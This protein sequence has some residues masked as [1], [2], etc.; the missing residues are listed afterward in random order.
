MSKD[1]DN[2]SLPPGVTFHS[3]QSGPLG[4]L[5]REKNWGETSLGAA[6]TWPEPLKRYVSMIL[7]LPIPAIV[8]WG[9]NQIQIYNDSYSVTMGPRHPKFLGATYKECWP[10]TYPTIY[11]WMLQVLEKGE[12]IKVDRTLIPLT[13]YGFLE[14]CFFT[15]S[16]TPLQDDQKKIGGILQLVTDMTQTVLS[17]RR[18]ATLNK[19]VPDQRS[20]AEGINAIIK[21]LASNPQDI[22][23]A[24]LF[25]P[26]PSGRLEVVG[27]VGVSST[28]KNSSLLELAEEVFK[29]NR[30]R[31]VLDLQKWLPHHPETHW[32]ELTEKAHLIPLR[33]SEMDSPLGVVL[34]GISPRLAFDESYQDF[35]NSLAR[36]MS[37]NLLAIQQR[38]TQIALQRAKRNAELEREKL[39][40]LFFQAPAA[41]A[42]LNLPDLTFDFVNKPYQELVGKSREHLLGVPIKIVFPDLS[43][44]TQKIL[45]E[46]IASGK[47]YESKEFLMRVDWTGKSLKSERY[48]NFVYTPFV[49]SSETVGGVMV[50]AFDVTDQVVERRKAKASE[51]LLR[52]VTDKLPALIS[53]MDTSGRYQF[54]NL[55]YSKWFGKS[56]SEI[57]GKTRRD[58]LDNEKTYSIVEPHESRA[59]SGQPSSLELTLTKST[60]EYVNL[61]TEYLPDRSPETGEVIGII[62]VGHDVTLRKRALQE[63]EQAQ[64]ELRQLAV[65]LK[66]ALNSRDEFMSI[67]SHELK[68]P[69]TSLKLQLQ[70]TQRQIARDIQ[71]LSHDKLTSVIETS[72]KQTNRLTE[73]VEDLLDVSRI[74]AGKL[75]F[76]FVEMNVREVIQEVIDRFSDQLEEAGC[77]VSLNVDPLLIAVWDRSRMEQVMVNLISNAVKYAPGKKID[78]NVSTTGNAVT[79]IV[80]DAGSGIPEELHERIFERFERA[81]A[82]RSIS[83][84]GLGL[85]IVRQI[86][87]GH[88]GTISLES[89]SGKATKF[90]I[91]LPLS[92]RQ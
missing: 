21:A 39:K 86:V 37:A 77:F 18:L 40:S 41:I 24:L 82:S 44:S 9:K 35:F 36:D 56:R 84:L 66:E 20:Q 64:G 1:N 38:E 33:R 74:R 63:A 46:V 10:D 34:L 50:F 75:V 52:N 90:I 53:Y 3:G 83:G 31:E 58:L 12:I 76:N 67:A 6:E 80:Q 92:S 65:D 89:G 62:G 2:N 47:S 70:M 55:A 59:F 54:V 91:E 14:E 60:G 5:I 72:M 23:C 29:S 45:D 43:L 7:S 87:L 79:I 15:F 13:R 85:F 71:G 22:R 30:G 81:T 48:L 51:E 69:I 78:I 49:D 19:L 11:P 8:F 32:H 61:D 28:E 57:V 42:I 25:F 68:T 73:L 16:L 88:N 26:D 27:T 17:E 4:E